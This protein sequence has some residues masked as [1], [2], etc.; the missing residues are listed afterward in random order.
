MDCRQAA[1]L[2][3]PRLDA[4]LSAVD[5]AA[6]E[7]HLAACP[8]C[9]YEYE[10]Q[11]KISGA[12]RSFGLEEVEAPPDMCGILMEKLRSE[13]QGVLRRLPAAWRRAVAA[14]AAVLLLAGGS[15]GVTAGLKLAGHDAGMIVYAPPAGQQVDVHGNSEGTDVVPPKIIEDDNSPAD[16]GNVNPG[17]G[18]SSGQP[19]PGVPN[20]E[21]P[22]AN[23]QALPEGPTALLSVMRVNHT[24]LEVSVDNME[25]AR[26]KV[27]EMALTAGDGSSVQTF[28]GKADGKQVLVMRLVVEPEGAT[29]LISDLSGLGTVV[30]RQDETSDPTSPY[31]DTKAQY[32]DLQLQ[33]QAAG[34]ATVRQQLE[35]RAAGL[36]Q[37]LETWE[38]EAGKHIIM[39]W[40]EKSGG[41]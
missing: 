7:D 11:V 35:Y 24:K 23:N 19:V 18:E 34:D 27:L 28:P 32:L 26:A 15:A 38:S 22:K 37:Q 30:D 13:R 29:R 20:A 5:N 10:L 4:A 16:V 8:A 9:R 40:L 12:L 41:S 25:S 21:P 36:K 31:Q 39:L 14:A 17:G 6:L 3:S 2:I 33:I 1:S